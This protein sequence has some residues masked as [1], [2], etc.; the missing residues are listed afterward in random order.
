MFQNNVL[1]SKITSFQ[2]GGPAQYF[3]IA[4]TEK[5]LIKAL[6]KAKQSKLAFYILGKASNVLFSDKGFKGLVIQNQIKDI[7][8]K[9]EKII[10]SSGVTLSYLAQKAKKNNLS[11]LEWALSIPG[12]I[13]GAV[14]INASA[15][16][17]AISDIVEKVRVLDIKNLKIKT[18]KNKELKFSKKNSLFLKNKS[19][20][21]LSVELKLKKEKKSV[22]QKK[23]KEY[24]LYRN[25]TQPL[26]YPS[27][28]CIFKNPYK[29]SA[30]FLI[31]QAGLKGKTIGGAQ[32]S[33]VHANYIINFKKARARDVL[34]LIKIIK[35]TVK[36]KFNVELKE[37]IQIIL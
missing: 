32:I 20:I 25:K 27:A 21:I 30:G 36:K 31:D 10:C 3:F 2:I 37:E 11:G 23:E 12:T 19:L 33:R 17:F 16:S 22:I 14:Y 24:N 29:K 7:K 1:L 35:K 8:V 28:G 6:K 5:D 13:G 4:K 15:F 34:E 18:L 9:K 26:N